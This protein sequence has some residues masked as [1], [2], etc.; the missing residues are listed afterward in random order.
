MWFPFLDLQEFCCFDVIISK[1]G[2]EKWPLLDQRKYQIQE[3][4]REVPHYLFPSICRA[5]FEE[6]VTEVC[7]TF[8]RHQWAMNFLTKQ[9]SVSMLACIKTICE[10]FPCLGNTSVGRNFLS[11][12]QFLCLM[13]LLFSHITTCEPG[14]CTWFYN[15]GCRCHSSTLYT[16]TQSFS[17]Q[18]YIISYVESTA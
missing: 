3:L 11:Q 2:Q 13:C 6:K 16:P 18:F 10:N 17:T 9:F 4:L 7:C 15:I 1:T 8:K 14:S 5:V 12:S